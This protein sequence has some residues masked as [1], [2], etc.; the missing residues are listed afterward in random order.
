MPGQG[1]PDH[2]TQQSPKL[3][4]YQEAIISGG[5]KD[6]CMYWFAGLISSEWLTRLNRLDAIE[7]ISNEIQEELNPISAKSLVHSF[8]P[9]FN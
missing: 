6:I 4:E 1:S 2:S 9:P 5:P 3:G 7:Y 8:G